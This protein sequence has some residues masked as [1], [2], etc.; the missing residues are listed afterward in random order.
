MI[1]AMA[2]AAGASGAHPPEGQSSG[3]GIIDQAF[4]GWMLVVLGAIFSVHFYLD[5]VH[6]DVLEI[7]MWSRAP[8]SWG[9]WKHPPL[10]PWIF[11]SWNLIVPFGPLFLGALVAL[12]MTVGA[13]ATWK[14]AG[15]LLD[16]RRAQTALCFYLVLPFTT[17]MPLKLNHNA[18]L[19]SLWPLATLALVT[20]LR[21]P[22]IMTGAVLGLTGA[23]AMLAKYFSGTLLVAL[24]AATL[25]SDR[26][27]EFWSSA[28]PYVAFLTFLALMAPHLLWYLDQPSGPVGYAL[29][30]EKGSRVRALV[31]V[32]QSIGLLVPVVLLWLWL[33]QRAGESWHAALPD[34]PHPGRRE[35][36]VVLLV[37]LLLTVALTVALKLRGAT[38]WAM[39]M[40]SMLPVLLA[41]ALPEQAPPPSLSRARWLHLAGAAVVVLSI[42]PV[43]ALAIGGA[44]QSDPRLELAR[45]VEAR[46][47]A[48]TGA[49]VRL[50]T[51]EVRLVTAA[52]WT[53]AD[54]PLGWPDFDTLKAPWIDPSILSKSGGIALC[55]AA[56]RHCRTAAYDA[57]RRFGPGLRIVE[58][59]VTVRRDLGI[60][61]GSPQSFVM[62]LACP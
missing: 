50:V 14:A 8:W 42:S 23:L 5:G 29:S 33:R 55:R 25:V 10:L 19:V 52:T 39:P 53:M 45:A 48:Q 15:L 18:V 28:A 11:K 57:L 35:L 6:H 60:V 17:V 51:G 16:A 31:F 61:K 62:I 49:P 20:A 54:R 41:G 21:R 34:R 1:K 38:A 32:L 3:D 43:A 12:N 4:F 58:E 22:S 2:A 24:F 56:D 7:A 37:P 46:W 47:R 36:I 44:A 9:F 27:K 13:W 30:S 59:V 26:R 40:F